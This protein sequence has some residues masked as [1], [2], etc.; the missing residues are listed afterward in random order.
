[1][2]K[3]IV[4]LNDEMHRELKKKVAINQETLKKIITNLINN[5]LYGQDRDI[6]LTQATGLC[7]LWIDERKS[8][9]IINDIK[10]QRKWFHKKS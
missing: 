8:D 4:E 3:L 1:M 10:S 2:G 5:Y 6:E 7:G 9:E